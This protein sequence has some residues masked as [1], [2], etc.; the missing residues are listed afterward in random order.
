[1]NL[2]APREA[3]DDNEYSFITIAISKVLS[4]SYFH[5]QF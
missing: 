1:M 3:A 5:V 4:S 2:A